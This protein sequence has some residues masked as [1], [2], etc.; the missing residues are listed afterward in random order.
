VPTRLLAHT[1][2]TLSRSPYFTATAVLS[3]AIGIGANTTIFTAANA[4]LF[5]PTTGVLDP[6]GLV[7][8]GRTTDGH[9]FD[10]VGFLTYQDVAA[11]R[12]VFSGVYATRIE[13]EAMSLGSADGAERIYAEFVSSSYFDVIGVQPAAGTFFRTDEE[14]PGV[15]LRKVVLTYAFWQRRFAGDAAVVGQAVRLNGDEFTVVGIASRGFQGTTILSPDLWVPL[16]A[17]A[18]STPTL[19]T[20]R[21][22]ENA[23]LIMGA[24][25]APGVSIGQA[26]QAMQSLSA[27][28]Q[29]EHP[30]VY[31][32]R[33]LTVVPNSRVPGEVGQFASAFLAVLM[34][35]VGLVQVVACTNLAG[36]ILARTTAR[37]REIAVRLALGASRGSIVGLLMTESLLLFGAGAILALAVSRWTSAALASVLTSL[38]VPVAVDLSLDWR[39]L[40]F[41]AGLALLTGLFTGLVPALQSTRSSLVPDLKA[42]AMTPR[43]RRLR[44]AFVGAQI[45]ACVVLVALAGLFVHALTRATD[46]DTGMDVDGVEVAGI[47]LDLSGRPEAEWSAVADELR[48]RFAAM[49]GVVSVGA[50]RM[51]PLQGG[52]MGLGAL[53]RAG[54]A[55]DEGRI[56]ADWNVVTPDFLSTVG[57]RLLRG[58]D[59][60]DADREGAAPVAVVSERL[61]ELAW[62]GDDPV[63]RVMECGDFRPG[64]ESTI[65]TVTVIGVARNARSRSL[66]EAPRAFVYVPLAQNP[67]PQMNFFIRRN[68]AAAAG[69][70]LETPT[71]A[72]LRDF[73]RNLPL[74]DMKS[75]REHADVGLLPQQIASA[76]AGLLG[77]VALALAAIGIYGVTAFAVATRTREIG[78]RV[79]LGADPSRIR[80]MVLWQGMRVTAIGGGIGLL[81]ALGAAQLASGWLFGVPPTD[82]FALGATAA[83]IGAVAIA[84]SLA[85][86]RRAAR[87]DPVRALRAE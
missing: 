40:G 54:D 16:T 65:S 3:L 66:G 29:A 46:V 48:R 69:P 67:R 26:G 9:G 41:T 61:A 77:S 71:R 21:G 70:G 87:L 49:P 62:P 74:V 81:A 76:V 43:R 22:R 18:R 38:P 84:A 20:L 25:L 64:R 1:V 56:D 75:F 60:T 27:Q 72:M 30:E 10:T 35:L 23:W 63:G 47:N 85:P 4:L 5:A 11:R 39:V 44:H 13:P 32:D 68:P 51:V 86:A 55:T 15:P 7:D 58:R 59:F 57:I 33:G 52:G 82:P 42:D 36:L 12:D 37:A 6:D 31:R 50:A 80:W 28:L 17:H 8:I 34:S 73:D 78:V 83:G 53:R 14:Q 2:R 19:E 79:A 45:A 24:R